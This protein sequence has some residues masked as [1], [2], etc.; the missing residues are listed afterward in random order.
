MCKWFCVSIYTYMYLCV[1]ASI[2]VYTSIECLLLLWVLLTC[3]CKHICVCVCIYIYIYIYI[4]TCIFVCMCVCMCIYT[5][6]ECLS[7]L[8]VLLPECE[9]HAILKTYTYAW[10]NIHTCA[11]YSIHTCTWYNI[12][13][14]KTIPFCTQSC[15]C[16]CRFPSVYS[17][18]PN[19]GWHWGYIAL[20]A[21]TCSSHICAA[22]SMLLA[23]R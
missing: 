2:C 11:W 17:W 20:Y 13:T 12:H 5:S 6:V 4:Y 10:Y 15:S 16:T 9:A 19:I 23:S 3:V 1:Y 7:P 8:W 22:P 14:H 18:S 21:C